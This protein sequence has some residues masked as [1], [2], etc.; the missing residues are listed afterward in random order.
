MFDFLHKYVFV[1]ERTV[2]TQAAAGA[3]SGA[4]EAILVLTIAENLK[5]K[6]IHD[7]VMGTNKY[8]NLLHGISTIAK[9]LGPSGLYRGCLPQVLKESSSHAIRFPVFSL[10]QRRAGKF[11]KRQVPRDFIAVGTAGLVSVALNNPIDVIKSNL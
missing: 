4:A 10:V 7:R 8:K 2:A 9:E 11:V 3:I 1:G 5:I 6:L